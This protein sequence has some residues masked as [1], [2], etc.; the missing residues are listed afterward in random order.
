MISAEGNWLPTSKAQIPVV[1][2][3]GAIDEM[4]SHDDLTCASATVEDP[5]G[6]LDGSNKE[7]AFQYEKVH[8]VDDIQ[9]VLLGFVICAES[10]TSPP[11]L[12][13]QQ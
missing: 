10:L 5:M 11:N 7:V 12:Q 8:M 6:V 4:G 13:Q 1:V 9:P 2:F 3:S